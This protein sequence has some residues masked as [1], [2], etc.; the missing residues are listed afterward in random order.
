MDRQIRTET[1]N[2]S[3]SE[4][5]DAVLARLS[6]QQI[7]YAIARRESKNVTEACAAIGM[8][9]QGYYDWPEDERGL[10]DEAVRLMEH[11]GVVTA[12]HLRRRALAEAMGVK[13]AGLRSDDEKMRQDVATQVIEWELGKAKQATDMNL[14]GDV[15]VTHGFDD[16]L[17]K[18]Y[19]DADAS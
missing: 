16:A 10:I 15:K 6:A 13:V 3:T 12:L 1:D 8:R 18:V 19:G 17:A 7:R 11:D 4:A 9:R 5:L 2:A 14:H